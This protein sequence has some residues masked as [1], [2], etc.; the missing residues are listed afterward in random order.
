MVM[1][2]K[3]LKVKELCHQIFLK[4]NFN[5]VKSKELQRKTNFYYKRSKHALYDKTNILFKII[6]RALKDESST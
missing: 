1:N 6:K 2:H 5:Y 3:L 4:G